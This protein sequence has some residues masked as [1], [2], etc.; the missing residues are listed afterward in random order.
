MRRVLPVF[1]AFSLLIC[2]A[3]VIACIRGQWKGDWYQWQETD[4][5]GNTWRAVSVVTGKSGIYVS[6]QRF[7]FQQPGNA[8]RYAKNLKRVSGFSHITSPPQTNPYAGSFWNRIGF[9]FRLEKVGWTEGS[10][11]PYRYDF[12]H[13]H[14]PYWALLAGF[15]GSAIWGFVLWHRRKRRLGAGYCENCGY[16]LR[17]TPDRCPECGT[18]PRVAFGDRKIS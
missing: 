2:V 4:Q 13:T 15:G 6:W 18:V 3:L 14:V 10:G 12:D 9:G 11:G 5:V 7:D 1:S 16:D 17:A 8:L